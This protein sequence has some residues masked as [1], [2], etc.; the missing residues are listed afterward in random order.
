MTSRK[1]IQQIAKNMFKNSLT[2]G[3]VDESKVKKIIKVVAS[4]K[5]AQSAKILRIYKNLIEKALLQEEVIIE[6]ASPFNQSGQKALLTKTNAKRAKYKI[7]PKMVLGAKITHGDWI[8]DASLD[9]KLKQLT[10]ES[11]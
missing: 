6:T 3:L 2:G 11:I 9:A 7:D 10:A 5:A 1:K 8:F 4:S